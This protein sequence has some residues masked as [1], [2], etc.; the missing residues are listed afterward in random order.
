[1]AGA[2]CSLFVM[3]P[4]GRGKGVDVFEVAVMFISYISALLSP[5]PSLRD[6]S[7]SGGH[8]MAISPIATQSLK[9]EDQSMQ[10]LDH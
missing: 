2:D 4:A 8:E 9:G 1:M 10:E 6:T 3:S 5:P 7:V